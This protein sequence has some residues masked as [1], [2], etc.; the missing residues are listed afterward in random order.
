M[1]IT[2]RPIE[3]Q[4]HC[5]DRVL[6]QKHNVTFPEPHAASMNPPV[7]RMHIF[8]SC[9]AC[10]QTPRSDDY[11]HERSCLPEY[12]PPSDFLHRSC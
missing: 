11:D 10:D 3:M 1:R 4:G 8:M 5:A 7:L 12:V 9:R 2:T 6:S